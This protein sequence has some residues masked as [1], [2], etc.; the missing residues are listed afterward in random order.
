MAAKQFLCLEV[1]L[2]APACLLHFAL[3]KG[4]VQAG[5]GLSPASGRILYGWR[6]LERTVGWKLETQMSLSYFLTVSGTRGESL[7]FFCL[8]SPSAA[9][10]SLSKA[11]QIS[12]SLQGE[13]AHVR[14]AC[15]TGD[16][17]VG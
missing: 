10:Q 2:I 14:A 12:A 15:L 8:V 16:P 11:E 5:W 13:I 4:Y 1:A 6:P 9:L 7:P 3:M 17:G